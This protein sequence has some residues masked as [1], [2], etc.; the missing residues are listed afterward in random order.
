VGALPSGSPPVT[1]QKRL[2]AVSLLCS[3]TA[4]K[5]PAIIKPGRKVVHLVEVV[6]LVKV[7]ASQHVGFKTY[8]V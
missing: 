4:Q 5:L 8:R 3:V 2:A 7:R 1:A 6:R